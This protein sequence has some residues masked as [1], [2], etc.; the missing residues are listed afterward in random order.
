MRVGLQRGIS[1]YAYAS[2]HFAGHAP[3]TIAQF[4]KLWK[5]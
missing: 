4:L 1:I 3:A 2:D 5:T